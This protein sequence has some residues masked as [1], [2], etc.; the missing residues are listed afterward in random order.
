MTRKKWALQIKLKELTIDREIITDLNKL[1]S[2]NLKEVREIQ[3]GLYADG[4]FQSWLTLLPY[5]ED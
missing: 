3:I 5:R 1:K 4:V 2:I